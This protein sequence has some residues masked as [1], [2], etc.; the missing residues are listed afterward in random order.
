VV[1][2]PGERQIGQHLVP[3]VQLVEFDR[4]ARAAMTALGL[5]ITPFERP[6][7]PDV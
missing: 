5:I 4:V 6:V 2:D 1:A 3:L 7:V